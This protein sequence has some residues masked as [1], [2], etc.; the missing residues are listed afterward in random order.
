[1]FGAV[2]AG[3]LG[4]GM[5]N[6]PA[7]ENQ[8][9]AMDGYD[10]AVTVFQQMGE[11]LPLPPGQDA[12]AAEWVQYQ[13]AILRLY[14]RA[15]RDQKEGLDEFGAA[16]IWETGRVRGEEETAKALAQARKDLQKAGV[17]EDEAWN[18]VV[19]A[20]NVEGE[21]PSLQE[22]VRRQLKGD[23]KNN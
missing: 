3:A 16:V 14:G 12:D 8:T 1:M 11:Q 7:Q 23:A 19:N 2:L 9:G 10:K 18:I 6:I 15:T 22:K 21:N 20:C 4:T 17:S 13:D 5:E